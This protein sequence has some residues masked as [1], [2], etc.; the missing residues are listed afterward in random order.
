[1]NRFF[2]VLESWRGSWRGGKLGQVSTIRY[3][4]LELINFNSK[5][6]FFEVNLCRYVHVYSKV[7]TLVR[8]EYKSQ[9]VFSSHSNK[10]I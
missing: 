8:K 6:R 5:P 10:R 3:R 7:L 1:M 9:Y 4:Y 2:G